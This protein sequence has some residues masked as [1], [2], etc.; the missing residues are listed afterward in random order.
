MMKNQY[1][2]IA[3]TDDIAHFKISDLYGHKDP[4]FELLALQLKVRWSKA[5][6]DE[7]SCPD[8]IILGANDPDFC[9]LIALAVYLEHWMG[10]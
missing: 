7:R 6:L 8:Q 1:H 4:R 2:L 5:V 9:L 3:R 10:F